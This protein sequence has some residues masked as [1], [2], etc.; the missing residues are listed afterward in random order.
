VC[1]CVCVCVCAHTHT[2]TQHTQSTYETVLSTL[3]ACNNRRRLVAGGKSFQQVI[4][5]DAM[6]LQ[7]QALAKARRGAFGACA[8]ACTPPYDQSCDAYDVVM[9]A[10]FL[11]SLYARCPR[12]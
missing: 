3:K 2:H 10:K 5:N 6:A 9:C 1:V 7:M 11:T 8:C 4:Y 12:S